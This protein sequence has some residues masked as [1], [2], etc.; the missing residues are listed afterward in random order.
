ME[1]LGL[2]GMAG[3][4]GMTGLMGGVGVRLVSTNMLE[5]QIHLK[6]WCVLF[7]SIF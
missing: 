5:M 6:Q 3:M 7:F 1:V 4:T 2:S